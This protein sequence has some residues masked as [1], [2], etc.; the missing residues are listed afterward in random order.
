MWRAAGAH[1]SEDALLRYKP[2]AVPI[3]SQLN[4][5]LR[6]NNCSSEDLQPKGIAWPYYKPT[7]SLSDP[8]G[9]AEEAHMQVEA[10]KAASGVS[11]NAI[12]VEPSAAG[13]P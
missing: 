8:P 5:S 4:G 1:A 7:A 11:R 9:A 3:E 12:I 13:F 2:A 6:Q 10:H